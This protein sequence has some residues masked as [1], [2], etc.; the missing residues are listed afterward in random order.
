M[1]LVNSPYVIKA[2]LST[3]TPFQQNSSY[4]TEKKLVKN[5]TRTRIHANIFCIKLDRS[6]FF[7]HF[8]KVLFC[9]IV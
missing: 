5:S 1:Y 7:P 9:L 6:I 8:T 4:P 3:Q 2:F